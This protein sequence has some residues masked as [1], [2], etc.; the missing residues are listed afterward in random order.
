MQLAVIPARGGS[1]RIPRKNIKM[2]HGQPMIAWSIQAA[3]ESGCFDEVWV[4]TDDEEIAEVAQVYGAKVPFLRPVHLSDDFATT[5]DVMSHA[6]EEFGKINHALPDY[7]CCLYATAP[8]VTKADLVQ[9]LEKIK[10][11]SNL[12]YVF[13]ATTYPFP[14][15]RAIK[16]N[17][18]DTVEMFSPQYFNVRS[19]DLEE[20]WHDAGQFYWGTAEAWLNKA[21]IFSTQSRVVELPRFRVQDIDT[22]EDWDRAEWL[23]KA[24]QQ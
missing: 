6:V 14:I 1:K 8:F 15:Q 10:N 24:I 12:N 20:A 23:F 17:E 7:I 22:Q 5:A 2:F 18:H 21:M 13:S 11:N 3:I 16:L 4:S 19:Q 9:G